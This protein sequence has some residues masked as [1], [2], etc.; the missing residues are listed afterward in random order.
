VSTTALFTPSTARWKCSKG[1]MRT[2]VQLGIIIGVCILGNSR[3][4]AQSTNI[5]QQAYF[6][7]TVLEQTPAGR[8]SLVRITNKDILTA[9]NASGDY[10]FG[11]GARLVFVST[12]NQLPDIV[13]RE[14]SGGQ[15][16][17]TDVGNNFGVTEQGDEVHSLDD[18]IRWATW[19]FAFDN[20]QETD[21]QLWGFTTLY[22]RAIHSAGVGTIRGIYGE[23]SR[24]NGVGGIRGQNAVFYGSVSGGYPHLEVN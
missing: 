4:A 8:V 11:T 10:N 23:L 12:D 20:G 5:I 2:I 22:N 13:V 15:V 9:L 7:L 6:V 19:V 18:S 21:F 3:L 17:T 14:G 24:V 16:T 1:N